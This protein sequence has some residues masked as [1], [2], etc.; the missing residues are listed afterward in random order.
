MLAE[1]TREMLAE[2]VREDNRADRCLRLVTGDAM[3]TRLYRQ[4]ESARMIDMSIHVA[5][6]RTACTNDRRPNPGP[7][8]ARWTLMRWPG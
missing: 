2:W 8:W 4:L 5:R 7:A 6:S 1:W 3:V